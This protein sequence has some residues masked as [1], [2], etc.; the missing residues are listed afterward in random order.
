ME[1]GGK[2]QR[3]KIRVKETG[4]GRKNGVK[5]YEE[6]AGKVKAKGETG[7]MEEYKKD[8]V[9]LCMCVHACFPSGRPEDDIKVP[10]VKQPCFFFYLCVLI[11]MCLSLLF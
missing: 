6:V 3:K 4:S 2:S 1:R 7:E 10:H 8:I 11:C 5:V 9:I